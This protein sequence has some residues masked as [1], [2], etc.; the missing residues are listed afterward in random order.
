MASPLYPGDGA[1]KLHCSSSFLHGVWQ[2]WI[3]ELNAPVSCCIGGRYI[4]LLSDTKKEA[5]RSV[6]GTWPLAFVPDHVFAAVSN[7]YLLHGQKRQHDICVCGSSCRNAAGRCGGRN[8]VQK[9]TLYPSAQI[10][11]ISVLQKASAD[12]CFVVQ[13]AACSQLFCRLSGTA[14]ADAASTDST[15]F[16]SIC[17]F[18]L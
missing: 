12:L 15:V 10:V 16:R 2:C 17:A 1:V 6:E 3:C 5:C 11:S 9:D 8:N 14:G 7:G 18:S 13:S 4:T